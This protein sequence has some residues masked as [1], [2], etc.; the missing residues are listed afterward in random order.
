LPQFSP[1]VQLKPLEISLQKERREV[2][3][4]SPPPLSLRAQ[5]R[6]VPVKIKETYTVALPKLNTLHFR[7]ALK[8]IPAVFA[9]KLAVQHVVKSG[10]E[11]QEGV[12]HAQPHSFFGAVDMPHVQHAKLPAFS[13]EE[14]DGIPMIVE[15][16]KAKVSAPPVAPMPRIIR[17][18]SSK[19]EVEKKTAEEKAR[20]EAEEEALAQAKKQAEEKARR[21]AEEAKKAAAERTAREELEQA[22]RREM[23]KKELKKKEEEKLAKKQAEEKARQ[24]AEEAKKAAEE[25]K[26][27]DVHVQASREVSAPTAIPVPVSVSAPA[28]A[29]SAPHASD[30]LEDPVTGVMP[31][32]QKT[33]GQNIFSNIFRIPVSV[34]TAPQEPG[35][36]SF[37]DIKKSP[38][39][40]DTIEELRILTLKDFRRLSEDPL[41]AAS[42]IY[43]KIQAMERES[44]TKKLTAIQAWREN[45]I[46]TLYVRIGQDALLK[47]K[48]ITSVID[49]L[50]EEKKPYL[51][52]QEFDAIL[53]LNERIRM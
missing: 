44:F 14:V 31:H 36:V 40:V 49:Q 13:I 8:A 9:K 12:V 38:R 41:Q 43:D 21:E 24:E 39:L 17:E 37:S 1:V 48:S 45:E 10:E 23:L 2:V 4:V 22:A 5:V 6:A 18:T 46:N 25:Q 50:K 20:R 51:T 28:P 33:S 34:K 3:R 16:Q 29:M 35:K 32:E 53:E 27:Q 11:L 15:K 19:E 52:E 30:M 26:A 42:R 47:G 7:K